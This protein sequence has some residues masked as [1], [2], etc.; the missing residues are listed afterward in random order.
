MHSIQTFFFLNSEIHRLK[1]VMIIVHCRELTLWWIIWNLT[2]PLPHPTPPKWLMCGR[3]VYIVF[4]QRCIF[5]CP[6]LAGGGGWGGWHWRED[7]LQA[8]MKTRHD[9]WL[10]DTDLLVLSWVSISID[11]QRNGS[12]TL[13]RTVGYFFPWKRSKDKSWNLY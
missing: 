11:N 6:P 8:L 5:Q 13:L 9:T 10:H 1:I 7:W 12:A 3:Y 4:I 2:P